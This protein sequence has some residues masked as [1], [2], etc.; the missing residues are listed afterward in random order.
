M[1]TFPDL[2]LGSNGLYYSLKWEIPGQDQWSV[3]YLM[4]MSNMIGAS[5]KFDHENSISIGAGARGM[6]LYVTDPRARVL[7]TNLVPTGG[8]FWDKNNSLMASLTAS[9]QRDQSVI[10][11]VYPGVFE[12]AGIRPAIW[13][14]WGANGTFGVGIAFQGTLGIGYREQQNQSSPPGPIPK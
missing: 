6:N 3:F 2:N 7:S 13:S 10:L 8:V 4:G 9:G 14:A 12:I 11:N 5:Y 1:I